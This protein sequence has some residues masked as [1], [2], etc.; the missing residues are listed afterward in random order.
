MI[1]LLL[2]SIMFFYSG[3]LVIELRSYLLIHALCVD[4]EREK[5]NQYAIQG[6]LWYGAMLYKQHK[7]TWQL[8]YMFT[9]TSIAGE[10]ITLKFARVGRKRV[11]IQATHEKI[12]GK[13]GETI[14]ARCI[15]TEHNEEYGE[16]EL[17]L[18]FKQ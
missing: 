4:L 2:L 8:P 3:Y 11:V 7:T 10:S 5:K 15:I 16:P 1:I 6:A 18:E 9:Y 14:V 12:P 17:E 13:T